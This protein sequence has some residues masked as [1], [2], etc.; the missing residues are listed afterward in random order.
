M[1]SPF[2]YDGLDS[3]IGLEVLSATPDEVRATLTVTAKVLQPYGLLHGGV[4][5]SIVETLGSVGSAVWYGDRGQVVGAS[6][7][8]DFYRSAREGDVLS[9]VATP[10]H[11]G[12]TQ[13]VWTVRVTDA[14][15][16]LVAQGQLRVANLPADAR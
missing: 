6:N 12:R 5:C 2:A 11:R 9:A 15:D 1:T 10:V 8:T 14:S 16:R 4:L 3:T 7:T 13:Q